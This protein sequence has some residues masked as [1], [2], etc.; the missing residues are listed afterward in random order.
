[1]PQFKVAER[2]ARW[3]PVRLI[4]RR[5]EGR[6]SPEAAL[7]VGTIMGLSDRP[8]RRGHCGLIFDMVHYLAIDREQKLSA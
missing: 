4:Y 5:S 2:A 7:V 8:L 1:M 6:R 3:P